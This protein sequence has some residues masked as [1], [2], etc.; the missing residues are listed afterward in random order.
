SADAVVAAHGR[1][2]W[3]GGTDS[4]GEA[5]A[6]AVSPNFFAVL[7]VRVARGRG[8]IADDY[9]PGAPSVVVL[10]D[11]FWRSRFGSDS[12]AL[13][14]PLEF[15]GVTFTIVGVASP[16]FRFELKDLALV[17]PLRADSRSSEARSLTVL[18]RLVPAATPE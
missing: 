15:D 4:D 2:G 11:W 9:R 5:V 7:G 10:T 18:A 13:G 16:S 6:S 8:L 1:R 12:A 3:V 14:R 17:I